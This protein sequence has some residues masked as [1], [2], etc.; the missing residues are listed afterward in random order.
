MI[1]G[2]VGNL[3][4]SCQIPVSIEKAKFNIFSCLNDS[5]WQTYGMH[6]IL[7]H[8]L[9]LPYFQFHFERIYSLKSVDFH[10]EDAYTPDIIIRT[11][12]NFDNMWL[13]LILI[14][15]INKNVLERRKN[16]KRNDIVF[17]QK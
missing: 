1:D 3:E 8:D 14:V 5:A 16:I 13:M 7:C 10:F 9:K 12:V 15:I 11:P 4:I 17:V 2:F 6:K